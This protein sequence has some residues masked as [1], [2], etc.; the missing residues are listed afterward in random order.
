MGAFRRRFF[1]SPSRIASPSLLACCVRRS[2]PPRRWPK[3]RQL[4]DECRQFRNACRASYALGCLGLEAV[5]MAR[6]LV[7]DDDQ[8]VRATITV[9][10]EAGGFEVVAVDG[11]RAGQKAVEISRFDATI[12]D[13]F[14]PGMDGL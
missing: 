10:L 2:I 1:S 5:T 9:V 4:S 7:I 11:G 14:M 6:V 3:L 13:V 8:P 12:V